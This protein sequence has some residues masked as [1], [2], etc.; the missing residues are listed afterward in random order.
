MG[1]T[2]FICF[3]NFNFNSDLLLHIRLFHSY[4]HIND[5]KCLVNNSLKT[6]D[7][8]NSFGKNIECHQA[9]VTPK[10]LNYVPF[11]N[12]ITNSYD[13]DSHSI[14]EPT[15]EISVTINFFKHNVH[16]KSIIFI[17]KWYNESVIPKNKVKTIINDVNMM[18]ETNISISKCELNSI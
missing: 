15:D 6:F 9:I 13:N 4:D 5:Y 16:N 3:M 8:L 18:Q 7:T 17:N 12:N 1:F 2:C 14:D 11:S 10:T